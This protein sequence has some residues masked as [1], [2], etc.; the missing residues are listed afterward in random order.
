MNREQQKKLLSI[1]K[2]PIITDKTTKL[3][4]NNQYCF[5]VNHK[6]NKIEI[7][8]AIEYIFNVKV[9]KINTYH[10]PRKK[11]TVARFK[12][13]KAHYKK[14]IVTLSENDTINLFSDN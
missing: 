4:E 11:R 2:K 14:A 10:A 5:Q 7:K 9:K 3:L 13:Y 12:G 1:I 8:L 6:S